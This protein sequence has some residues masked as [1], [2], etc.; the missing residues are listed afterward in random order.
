MAAG[1]G[2]PLCAFLLQMP[3][4]LSAPF[5]AIG[6]ASLFYGFWPQLSRFKLGLRSPASD[7]W[8]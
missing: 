5:Q 1:L 7:G 6:Y 8:R 4:E 2:Y 3:R